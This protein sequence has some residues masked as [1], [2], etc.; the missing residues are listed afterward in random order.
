[1]ER[2]KKITKSLNDDSIRIKSCGADN[3]GTDNSKEVSVIEMVLTSGVACWWLCMFFMIHLETL[4]VAQ[5]L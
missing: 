2:L 5:V 1:V 4:Q 3:I